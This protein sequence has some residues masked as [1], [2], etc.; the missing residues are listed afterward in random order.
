MSSNKKKHINE[1]EQMQESDEEV[2]G[3]D[4]SDSEEQIS[5]GDEVNY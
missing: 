4:D 5:P 1:A 2:S 3:D